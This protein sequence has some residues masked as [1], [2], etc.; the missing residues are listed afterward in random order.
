M[1]SF[2]MCDHIEGES[3]IHLFLKMIEKNEF[4][5]YLPGNY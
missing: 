4:V 2:Q 5:T 1:E 3:K